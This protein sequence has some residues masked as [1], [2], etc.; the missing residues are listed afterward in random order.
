[1]KKV[2]IASILATLILTIPLTSV[3][4]ANEVEDCLECQPVNRFDLLKVKLLMIRLETYTNI[5]LSKFGFISEIEEKCQEILDHINSN[6]V[7]EFTLICYFLLVIYF[8]VVGVTVILDE[9]LTEIAKDNPKLWPIFL[10]F[11][12]PF[13][14]M[15]ETIGQTG[16]LFDCYWF[17]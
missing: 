12:I 16:K 11:L 13:Y 6:R 10:V 7:L 1:M 9:I 15:C 14:V 4:S 8:L 2:W 3:V 17:S 5:I